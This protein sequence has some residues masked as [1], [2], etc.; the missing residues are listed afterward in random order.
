MENFTNTIKNIILSLLGAFIGAS[1]V[2]GLF[3]QFEV[4][5]NKDNS[6]TQISTKKVAGKT[7][8]VALSKVTT[9]KSTEA[10]NKVK[11]SVVT[12]ENLQSENSQIPDWFKK[13]MEGREDDSSGFDNKENDDQSSNEFSND[14]SDLQLASEGSGVIF[15]K[16]NKFVYIVTNNHVIEKAN[17]LQVISAEGKKVDAQLVGVDEGKDLAVIKVDASFSNNIVEFENSS[18]KVGQTVLAIG[19]PLGSSYSSSVTQGIISAIDRPIKQDK[20]DMNVLQTDAAI[21]PG[22]SGG[23]LIDLNG[24][25]VGINSMKIDDSGEE[26]VSVEGIGFAIPS[27]TVQKTIDNILKG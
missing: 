16:D 10:Y 15:K 12:V 8:T 11:N 9:E 19:S 20:I 26:G 21:N 1:V 5:P 22:N 24:K 2:I 3:Y 23:A 6:K 7:N 27:D 4:V 18:V 13:W 14:D 17:K 25:L